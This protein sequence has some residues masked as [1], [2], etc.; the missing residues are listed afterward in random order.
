MN[1]REEGRSVYFLRLVFMDKDGE[2]SNEP[3]S[4]YVN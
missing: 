1:K 4:L 3:A 2:H